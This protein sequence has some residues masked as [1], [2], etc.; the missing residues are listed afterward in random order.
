MTKICFNA[1][2]CRYYNVD[3]YY[4]R[5]MEREVKKGSKKALETERTFH[6]LFRLELLREHERYKEEQLEELKHS[7]QSGMAQGQ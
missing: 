7:M 5:K 4:R 3:A 6:P 2:G 1:C